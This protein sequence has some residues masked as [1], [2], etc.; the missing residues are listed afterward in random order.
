MSDGVGRR[1]SLRDLDR[2]VDGRK[3]PAD[4]WAGVHAADNAWRTGHAAALVWPSG[5]VQKR[6]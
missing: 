3:C 2:M 6:P 1:V 5:E 4:F